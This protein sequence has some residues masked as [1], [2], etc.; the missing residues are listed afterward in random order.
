MDNF[1]FKLHDQV[2]GITVFG[3][4][5]A[6]LEEEMVKQLRGNGYPAQ[7]IAKILSISRSTLYNRYNDSILLQT[8]EKELENEQA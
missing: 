6:E 1:R 7:K 2:L 4:N 5:F 8:I 3:K